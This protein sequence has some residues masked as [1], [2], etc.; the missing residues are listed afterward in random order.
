M[1]R[2]A[3]MSAVPTALSLS[4]R[5]DNASALAVAALWDQ[6][7]AFEDIPSMRPLDYPPHLTF[8][9]Y[10]TYDVSEELTC[11]GLADAADEQ[12][13]LRIKFDR[14]CI[15]EGPPLVLW[16]APEPREPLFQIAPNNPRQDQ[17]D[18]MST[19][20]P[21]GPLDTALRAGNPYPRRA[22][23]AFAE[24]FRG[25]IEVLFDAIDCMTFFPLR[26]VAKRRLRS[27]G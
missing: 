19:L 18:A 21:T 6:V 26:L 4:L 27:A 24:S 15:F 11:A 16:L 9:I 2:E 14:I 17:S 25:G 23:L 22:S 20:L 1:S 12:A 3:E 5:S 8:A 10:D 13:E 7:S